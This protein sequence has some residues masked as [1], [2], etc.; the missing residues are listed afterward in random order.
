MQLQKRLNRIIGD[1]EYSKWQVVIPPDTIE[2]LGWK[3]GQDLME[4]IDG[5]KLTLEPNR[6]NKD[7]KT[8]VDFAHRSLINKKRRA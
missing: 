7:S 4:V 8:S 3:E 5:K 2:K 6:E 1:K